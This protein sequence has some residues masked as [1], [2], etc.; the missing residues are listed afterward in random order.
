MSA[1]CGYFF[2]A[3][4]YRCCS[5]LA[6]PPM[7]ANQKQKLAYGAIVV[8]AIVLIG[9]WYWNS[10]K[11]C[12]TAGCGSGKVCSNGRC[13]TTGVAC[14]GDKDCKTGSTCVNKVCTP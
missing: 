4:V 1:S 8:L 3:P 11:C 5:D 14:T 10:Q 6:M 7:D 2:C 9:Y 13:R 12:N